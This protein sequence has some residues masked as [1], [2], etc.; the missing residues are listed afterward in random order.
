MVQLSEEEFHTTPTVPPP[1]LHL[2]LV[3]FAKH[4][5]RFLRRAPACQAPVD[6]H[7]GPGGAGADPGFAAHLGGGRRGGKGGGLELTPILRL[8]WEEGGG[9]GEWDTEL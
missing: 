2:V 3:V 5:R 8:I 7:G 9:G 1:C 4:H 6:P